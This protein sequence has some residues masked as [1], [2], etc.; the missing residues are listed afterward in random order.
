MSANING[1][2]LI[3][4]WTHKNGEYGTMLHGTQ[5]VPEHVFAELCLLKG[6]AKKVESQ[7]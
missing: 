7:P 4:D 6:L 2:W 5:R 1:I 3:R